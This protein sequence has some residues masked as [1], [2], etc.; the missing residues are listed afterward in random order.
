MT[1]RTVFP[2]LLAQAD[3]GDLE[4][5]KKDGIYKK[6]QE[7]RKAIDGAFPN[8]EPAGERHER[9]NRNS[10]ACYEDIVKSDLEP[11]DQ[12]N[13]LEASLDPILLVDQKGQ[14]ERRVQSK[15]IWHQL[16]QEQKLEQQKTEVS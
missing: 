4:E 13:A 7:F 10:Q 5:V 9:L 3:Q 6:D 11:L 8:A 12:E 15:R 16:K 2:F 1:N 14:R